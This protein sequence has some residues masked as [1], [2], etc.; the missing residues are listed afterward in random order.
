MI[1][2]FFPHSLLWADSGLPMDL[3]LAVNLCNHTKYLRDIYY[4]TDAELTSAIETVRQLL[5]A[6]ADPN[7]RIPTT[8]MFGYGAFFWVMEGNRDITLL[9]FSRVP[10]VS[11]LLIEYGARVND[12]DVYGRTVL[13]FAAF[14]DHHFNGK[15]EITKILIENGAEINARNNAGLTALYYAIKHTNIEAIEL[16]ISIGA[17][18]NIRDNRGWSPL[19]AAK[20]YNYYAFEYTETQEK[21]INIL[22]NAGGILSDGDIQLIDS[23]LQTN[24][25]WEWDEG[26]NMEAA[27]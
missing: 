7:M 3:Y 1:F 2:N 19:M 12:R 17:N 15:N 26:L 20:I 16:L 22:T 8:N 9:M 24:R 21:I 13:M 5:A 14:F 25:H 11:R 10:E 23:I 18:I 6:G 4:G 27:S